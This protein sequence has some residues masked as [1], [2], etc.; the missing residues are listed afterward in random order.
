M[1]EIGLCCAQALASAYPLPLSVEKS[2]KV[3]VICGPGNN[4]GDGL[5]AAR[6]LLSFVSHVT[7][8]KSIYIHSAPLCIANRASIYTFL[9]IELCIVKE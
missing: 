4:G 5:A 7:V 1:L 3:L 8:L 9:T 6:H 2:K